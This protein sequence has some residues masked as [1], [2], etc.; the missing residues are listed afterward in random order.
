MLVYLIFNHIY[1]YYFSTLFSSCYSHYVQGKH[2]YNLAHRTKGVQLYM[3]SR[4]STK[5]LK[6]VQN[7]W[8]G[9]GVSSC[10]WVL[11]LSCQRKPMVVA[12]CPFWPKYK[13]VSWVC[14]VKLAQH[15]K[16]TK[17]KVKP[18]EISTGMLPRPGRLRL[19]GPLV[20]AGIPHRNT[21]VIA[22][23]A[24]RIFDQGMGP[25]IWRVDSLPA[26]PRGRPYTGSE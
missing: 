8:R 7:A 13:R 18:V 9:P 3:K 23:S 4:L 12:P 16:V 20:H 1:I 22:F 24:I 19:R 6:L 15:Q 25:S 10:L 21:G 5:S 11:V 14:W 17:V 26:K 2:W